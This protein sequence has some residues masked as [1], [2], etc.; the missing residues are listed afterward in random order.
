MVE[1]D[2]SLVISFSS[3]IKEKKLNLDFPSFFFLQLLSWVLAGGSKVNYKKSP[4]EG[5]LVNASSPKN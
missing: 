2:F 4:L 3:L 5:I 1:R